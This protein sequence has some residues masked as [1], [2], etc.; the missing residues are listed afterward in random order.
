MEEKCGAKDD[1]IY[2]LE[3]EKSK[4]KM[5]FDNLRV[6][7]YDLKQKEKELASMTSICRSV[8]NASIQTCTDEFEQ[9]LQDMFASS[10]KEHQNHFARQLSYSGN[11][12]FINQTHFSDLNN[13]SMDNLIP[14]VEISLEDVSIPATVEVDPGQATSDAQPKKQKKKF[15]RLLKLMPCVSSK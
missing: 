13:T 3:Y 11:K 6:E 1:R 10:S 14:P 9:F 4:M 12:S 7:M 2:E 15:H 8:R 5:I